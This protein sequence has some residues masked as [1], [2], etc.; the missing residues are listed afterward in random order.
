MTIVYRAHN[1]FWTELTKSLCKKKDHHY[2]PWNDTKPGTSTPAAIQPRKFKNNANK[3]II[4]KITY[5]GGEGKGVRWIF[6]VATEHE[7]SSAA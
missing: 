3:W 7:F 5:A 6:H 4:E 1:C 2:N